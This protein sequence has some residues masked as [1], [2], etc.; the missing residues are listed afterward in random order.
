MVGRL[1]VNAAFCEM[2]E[3]IERLTLGEVMAWRIAMISLVAPVQI[4]A[5]TVCR[6]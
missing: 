5:T 6:G 2:G 4:T 1:G 3:L